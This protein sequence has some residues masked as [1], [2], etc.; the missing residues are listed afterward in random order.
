MKGLASPAP[1]IPRSSMLG[2][3]S[4]REFEFTDIIIFQIGADL[5]QDI[6]NLSAFNLLAGTA[7]SR[8]VNHRAKFKG[9]TIRAKKGAGPAMIILRSKYPF[10]PAIPQP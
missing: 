7:F 3:A 5:D 6:V 9:F 2:S 1:G 4:I 8:H 10:A